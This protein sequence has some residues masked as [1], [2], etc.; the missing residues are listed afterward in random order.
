M[1]N[2]LYELGV[3][4]VQQTQLGTHRLSRSLMVYSRTTNYRVQ[5]S[6]LGS[7]SLPLPDLARKFNPGIA[8]CCCAKPGLAVIDPKYVSESLLVHQPKSSF[9]RLPSLHNSLAP[10]VVTRDPVYIGDVES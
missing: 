5:Y 2:G 10:F 4:G 7:F 9:P 1:E 6:V 8:A 3:L